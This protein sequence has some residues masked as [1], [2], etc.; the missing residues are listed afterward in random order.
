MRTLKSFPNK[1]PSTLC[2]LAAQTNLTTF[3]GIRNSPPSEPIPRPYRV[4]RKF[5]VQSC[6]DLPRFQPR[7]EQDDGPQHAPRM[8]ET[9][10]GEL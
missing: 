7:L 10:D 6:T 8:R 1:F 4:N 2:S 3:L 9:L 5:L